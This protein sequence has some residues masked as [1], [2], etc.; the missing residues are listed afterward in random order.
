MASKPSQELTPGVG[1]KR[2][3]PKQTA[4][5]NLARRVAAV[6]NGYAEIRG[7]QNKMAFVM[8]QNQGMLSARTEA[9]YVQFLA[10]FEFLKEKG[11][12]ETEFS[13]LQAVVEERL[14]QEKLES[15]REK[16]KVGQGVCLGC[17]VILPG[18]SFEKDKKCPQCGHESYD[19][20]VQKDVPAEEPKQ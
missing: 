14:K 11:L 5:Q 18:T 20:K 8:A 3:P 7:K 9:S 6:E 1:G 19:I 17:L 12:T 2:I 15:I 13:R 10:L 4:K 16:L